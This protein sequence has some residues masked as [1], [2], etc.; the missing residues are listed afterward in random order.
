[1]FAFC[2]VAGCEE[3]ALHKVSSND[4]PREVCVCSP[5][6]RVARKEVI[7]RWRSR[8]TVALIESAL[9]PGDYE[10]WRTSVYNAYDVSRSTS[11]RS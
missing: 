6:I 4:H 5:H 10:A 2:E 9:V 1:M 11:V 3:R 8:V 7:V